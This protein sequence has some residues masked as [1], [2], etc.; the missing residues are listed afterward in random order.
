MFGSYIQAQTYTQRLH[1]LHNNECSLTVRRASNGCETGDAPLADSSR[2]T[3]CGRAVTVLSKQGTVQRHGHAAAS[4][5]APA[6]HNDN[7]IKNDD[8]CTV[9]PNQSLLQM[10]KS[11]QHVAH[12]DFRNVFQLHSQHN[13]LLRSLYNN[14][15]TFSECNENTTQDNTPAIFTGAKY[16]SHKRIRT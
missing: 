9:S 4:A 13:T 3:G 6:R 7:C 15:F 10:S 8:S 2:G 11:K 12:A 14:F 16:F 1:K 5:S